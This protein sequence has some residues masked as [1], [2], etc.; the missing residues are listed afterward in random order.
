MIQSV[1]LTPGGQTMVERNR[2]TR[3]WQRFACFG[4][5]LLSSLL[6]G[7]ARSRSVPTS[8]E[9]VPPASAPTETV[10]SVSSQA[11]TSQVGTLVRV[12]PLSQQ[13]EG[14]QTTTVEIRIGDV[15]G[16]W[17]AEIELWFNPAVLQVQDADPS[18]EDVQIQPG[19]FPSPDFVA[20]NKVDNTTGIVNY[21]LTQLP[22]HEPING[23][24]LLASVTFQ[25]ASEGTSDLTLNVVKLATRQGE[26]IP[27]T[28]EG[29]QITVKGGEPPSPT[30]T[31]PTATPTPEAT[32]VPTL[33]PITSDYYVV[34]HGDTLYSIARRCGVSVWQLAAHNHIYNMNL[35]SIGQVLAIP[36]A[37][38]APGD[39][40]VVQYGDTLYSI[41][42]RYG[43]SVWQLASY[44][45]IPNPHRIYA[46]QVIRIP[47]R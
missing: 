11:E 45:G 22:P 6:A 24:G 32:A 16:L 36:R 25:G 15:A 27:A 41:A 19:N 20:E 40:Y 44:N 7:C 42:R 3:S 31:P 10:P 18:E 29:S 23:S 30:P 43:L 47:P 17:G 8:T 5:I 39:H 37:G 35:I 4:M 9:T 14:G 26:P 28:S 38:W 13:I 12:M 33:P 21:A 1:T 2:P 46:G 34:Q